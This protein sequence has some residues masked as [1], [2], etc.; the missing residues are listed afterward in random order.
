MKGFAVAGQ[1][2]SALTQ[3]SAATSPAVVEIRIFGIHA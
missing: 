2:A 3:S 1:I